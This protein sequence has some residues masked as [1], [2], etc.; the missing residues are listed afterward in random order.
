MPRLSEHEL[1]GTIGMLKAGVRVSDVVRYHICHPSFIQIVTKLL[2]Q[3][4]TD[5]GLLSQVWRPALRGNLSQLCIDDIYINDIHFCCLLSLPDEWLG[6][7]GNL[8]LN[9]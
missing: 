7:K 1:S 6:S 3:L 9:F 4:K 8:F 5:A 2:G